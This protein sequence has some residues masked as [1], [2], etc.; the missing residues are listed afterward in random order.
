MCIYVRNATPEIRSSL[1]GGPNQNVSIA[2][3]EEGSPYVVN[4]TLFSDNS[5]FTMDKDSHPISLNC[6]FDN[7]TT[8]YTD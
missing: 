2:C 1:I 8:V 7:A 4:S 6:T 3:D 5:D